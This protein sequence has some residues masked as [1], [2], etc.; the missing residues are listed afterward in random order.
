[1]ERV[2]EGTVDQLRVCFGAGRFGGGLLPLGGAAYRAS[3]RERCEP[4]LFAFL[5]CG[6]PELLMAL[7][8]AEYFSL[9]RRAMAEGLRVAVIG[10][11]VKEYAGPRRVA[12]G[13]VPVALPPSRRFAEDRS[14]R[15]SA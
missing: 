12:E 3:E 14:V 11:V 10:R 13:G 7:E 15:G 1:M 8:P 4:S 5:E 2:R 9:E 6:E